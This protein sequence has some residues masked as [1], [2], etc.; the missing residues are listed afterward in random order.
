MHKS[1]RYGPECDLGEAI[2]ANRRRAKAGPFN[3]PSHFLE[4]RSKG[5]L[6]DYISIGVKSKFCRCANIIYVEFAA[7]RKPLLRI[8]FR[9]FKPPLFSPISPAY[10]YPG[11]GSPT[12][13]LEK[14]QCPA[15]SAESIPGTTPH[16]SASVDAMMPSPGAEW[17]AA[18][19]AMLQLPTIGISS[20]N[21]LNPNVS[22]KAMIQPPATMTQIIAMGENP[23]VAMAVLFFSFPTS[24]Y[25]D[26][27]AR[28]ML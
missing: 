25:S 28:N 4:I 2:E 14:Q 22:A 21:F 11:I 3:R 10:I 5:I 6:V 1:R 16:C 24:S 26:T 7:F 20:G 18:E 23:Q 12:L 9:R 13:S 19:M 27:I 17:Q 15:P 8:Y